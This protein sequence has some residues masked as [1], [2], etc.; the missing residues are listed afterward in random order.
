M[1]FLASGCGFSICHVWIKT[2]AFQSAS[3]TE[4]SADTSTTLT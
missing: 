2:M 4:G 3:R 1:N